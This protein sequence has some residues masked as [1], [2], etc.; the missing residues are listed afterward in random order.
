MNGQIDIPQTPQI[1]VMP[2]PPKH[3]L[4][5]VKWASQGPIRDEA[6]RVGVRKSLVELGAAVFRAGAGN[7]GISGPGMGGNWEGNLANLL[8]TM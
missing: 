7:P 1:V 4:K 2:S 3:P 6:R 8:L 5:P